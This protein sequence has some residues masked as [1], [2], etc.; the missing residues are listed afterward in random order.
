MAVFTR[1]MNITA[2]KG[3]IVYWGEENLI[4]GIGQQ[5]GTFGLLFNRDNKFYYCFTQIH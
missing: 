5:Q 4:W 3:T 2:V 1:V